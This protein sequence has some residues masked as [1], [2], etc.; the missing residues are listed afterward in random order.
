MPR[1][2]RCPTCVEY[3]FKYLAEIEEALWH[4]SGGDVTYYLNLMGSWMD[5][6]ND[7]GIPR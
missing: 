5:V 3:E 1:C 6:F 2:G 7:E 4:R